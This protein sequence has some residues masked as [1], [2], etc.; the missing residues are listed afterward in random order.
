MVTD[1]FLEY[2]RTELNRSMQTVYSY[3]LDLKQFE[4]FFESL[5][6]GITWERMNDGVV[7]EWVVYLLDEKKC[8]ARSVNRKLSSLRTFYKYM[9]R[10]GKVD[11]NPIEKILGPKTEKNLPSFVREEDMDRLLEY[12]DNDESFAGVRNKTV[13]MMFYHTGMR[14]AELLGLKDADID[15]DGCVLKVTGKRNKQR[16]IPFGGELKDAILKY[17]ECRMEFMQGRMAGSFFVS[18]SGLNLSKKQVGEIVKGCLGLVTAQAKRSPHV[19]RHTFATAM[20]NNKADLESIQK[21]LGH[22]SL[23]TTEIYTHLTFEELKDVYKDAHP[24]S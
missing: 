14:R 13:I 11:S 9:M 2:L 3:G 4:S 1:S 12:L 23:S 18:D 15:L 22:E 6:E 8:T 5:G 21:I 20:L 24:R 10:C 19:L 17:K 7:R 16:V